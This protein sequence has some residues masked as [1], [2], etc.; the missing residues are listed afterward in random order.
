MDGSCPTIKSVIPQEMS[1]FTADAHVC[2]YIKTTN[3]VAC[4]C[5]VLTYI[6]F[7]AYAMPLFFITERHKL[8]VTT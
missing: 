6:Q 2:C 7:A 1:L 8:I 4:L 3:T 5:D